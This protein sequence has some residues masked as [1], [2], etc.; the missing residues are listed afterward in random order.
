MEILQEDVF[1]SLIRGIKKC[2]IKRINN[3]IIGTIP[4]NVAANTF[5]FKTQIGQRNTKFKQKPSF[6]ANFSN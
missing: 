5:V 1:Y 4:I 3:I 6:L 2:I